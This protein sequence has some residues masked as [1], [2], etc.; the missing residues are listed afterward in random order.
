MSTSVKKK[1]LS[2]V[3]GVN[4]NPP[5]GVTVLSAF[6]H[7]GLISIFLLFPLLVCREAHLAP[8]KILDVLSLSMLA[9]GA[10]AILPALA[11]GPVGSGYLCPSIFTVAY[12]GPSL[13]AVKSG[14]LSLVFGMTVFA[15]CVEAALSRS[16]RHLRAPSWE[17]H[18]LP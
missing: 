1:P 6:Q 16:L 9:M 8:D 4:E 10:G 12:L 18:L 11:R 5:F 2:I 14:G 3:Y 13:L 15:G 17:R 7:V